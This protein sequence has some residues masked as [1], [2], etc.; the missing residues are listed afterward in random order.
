[1]GG[2]FVMSK[3]VERIKC[4]CD[5]CGKNIEFTPYQFKR[6]KHHFCSKECSSKGVSKFQSKGNNPNYRGG[7]VKCKCDFCG[8]EIEMTKYQFNRAKKHFCS[9][10]C[11]NKGIAYTEENKTKICVN[12]GEKFRYSFAK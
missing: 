7:K 3:R 8:K 4:K 9:I 6:S 12:C 2:L 5:I 11:K 1:M 10:D